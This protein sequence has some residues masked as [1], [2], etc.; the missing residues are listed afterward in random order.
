M[1]SDISG[2]KIALAFE[3]GVTSFI[4][5]MPGE[6][7]A[8]AAYRN[9]LNIPMDCREGACG[10]CKSLC[11]AGD[12]EMS[13]YIDEALSEDERAK[14]QVLTCKMKPLSDVM[15]R[16]PVSSAVCR[17]RPMPRHRGRV[18]QL[19]ALSP[20]TFFLELEL[21]E[22]NALD[23]LAGQY[24]NLFLPA[25]DKSRAYSF[26]SR[27]GARRVGFLIRNVPGGVM[28]GHLAQKARVG[29]EMEFDAP[30]GGFYLRPAARPVLMLAGGTGLAPFLSM[31][32]VM[33]ESGARQPIHL[34]YGVTRD[35][36][37]VCE[38]E[39]QAFAARLPGFGY[40][41]CVTES[42]AAQVKRGYV[43]DHL[44]A[45]HFHDGQADVYLCG[46]PPMVT[47][48]ERTMTERGL[49]SHAMYYEKFLP[50]Q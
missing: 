41:A 19:Q 14:G 10:T 13:D 6:T 49:K 11:E 1:S 42:Q 45:V 44:D 38:P 32:A 30:F 34:V 27:P 33:A 12:F 26:C 15:V 29:D 3:D 24:A 40:T 39:L 20:T 9:G 31:L 21:A 4:R 28:S 16:I 7:V 22:G 2:H 18:V 23:F 47:A 36:D 35:E 50:G 25:G 8:A 5:S 37:L 48:I 43:S 17:G 46:P